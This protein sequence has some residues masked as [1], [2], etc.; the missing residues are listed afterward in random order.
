MNMKNKKGLLLA[1]EIVNIVIAVAVIAILAIVAYYTYTAFQTAHARDQAKAQLVEITAKVEKVGKD[2]GDISHLYTSPK[3]WSLV[4]Y[5]IDV[6]KAN[7]NN[8]IPK[9]CNYKSCLCMCQLGINVLEVYSEEGKK[10]CESSNV[11]INVEA[12]VNLDNLYFGDQRAPTGPTERP[13]AGF[14]SLTIQKTLTFSELPTS[15]L[16]KKQGD[17]VLIS[18]STNIFMDFMDYQQV[19]QGNYQDVKVLIKNYFKSCNDNSIDDDYEDALDDFSEWYLKKLVDEGKIK[20]GKIA[21]T[22]TNIYPESANWRFT[23]L[24]GFSNYLV[25]D[26]KVTRNCKQVFVEKICQ[27][28]LNTY[29]SAEYSSDYQ[30]MGFIRFFACS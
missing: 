3:G 14:S 8:K 30:R 16:I 24:T 22:I 11:C 18:K 9:Q 17:N 5:N 7:P 1:D 29:Y 28:T 25:A 20:G 26:L 10:A 12:K 2:G 6:I 19:Y 21:F 4:Y 13:T 15:L 27:Q 23:S